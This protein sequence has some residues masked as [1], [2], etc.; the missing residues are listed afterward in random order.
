MRSIEPARGPRGD[1]GPQV[2]VAGQQRQAG[3]DLVVGHVRL[4]AAEH[5]VGD[6][7]VDP[8]EQSGQRGEVR[9]DGLVARLVVAREDADD[10]RRQRLDHEARED[11]ARALEISVDGLAVA[12]QRPV[13]D[14]A[15]QL[16][17]VA[18]APGLDLPDARIVG[19]QARLGPDLVQRTRD[20]L[21]GLQAA[22]VEHERRHGRAREAQEPQHRPVEPLRQVDP[23]VLDALALEHQ[24]DGVHRVRGRDGVERRG[25]RSAAASR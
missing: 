11:Q 8:V 7:A 2:V 25:H 23:L 19:H 20:R 13:R 5:A 16:L 17:E 21:G 10:G 4:G 22:A 14:P 6:P 3:G 9:S 24:R 18:V 15:S 12:D 1:H